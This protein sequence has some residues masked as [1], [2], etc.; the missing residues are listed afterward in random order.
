MM[1]HNERVLADYHANKKKHKA[2]Q[3]VYR[4]KNK[5]RMSKYQAA[6]RAR[7]KEE[8]EQAQKI[9]EQAKK[10]KAKAQ[11]IGELITEELT[12]RERLLNACDIAD[13][14]RAV[15]TTKIVKCQ[16]GCLPQLFAKTGRVEL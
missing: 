11:K 3:A 1:D 6:Y 5:G 14:K 8:R 2:R 10:A 15:S 9:L 13:N 16:P 7:M 12:T 4:A